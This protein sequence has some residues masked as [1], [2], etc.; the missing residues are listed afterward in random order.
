[1]TIAGI[2]FDKDGTLFDFTASWSNWAVALLRSLSGG[3]EALAARLGAAIGFDSGTRRFAPDSPAIAGTNAEVAGLLLPH[4]PGMT[5]RRLTG[6]MDRLAA[7]A[8]MVEIVPL[9][10]LME[11]LRARGLILGIATNDAEA[12]ARAHLD[13]AGIADAFGF[14]VGYDSGH[15]AKPGPGMCRAFA[16]FSGI[17]PGRLLMVGDSLH[18]LAAGR[19]AGLRSLAVASGPASGAALAPLAEAVL[20]DIGSLPCWLDGRNRD[21]SAVSDQKTTRKVGN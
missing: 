15:G 16:G 1:M 11:D 12:A 19:A 13:R 9:A 4:L 14:V 17:E 18:D 10:P 8:P 20:P 2:L 7:D 3:D 5:R 21:E 6:R